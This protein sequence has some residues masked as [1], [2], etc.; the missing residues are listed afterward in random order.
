MIFRDPKFEEVRH[1][2]MHLRPRSAEE[3]H[4]MA[5]GDLGHLALVFTD[6]P[7][8][9]WVAYHEDKPAAIFGAYRLHGGVWQ[10]FG[11]GTEDYADVLRAVTK[12]FR[13]DV[14]AAVKAA[15]A[16]RAQALSPA[17]HHETHK[18]LKMLGGFEEATLF[19]YG[20]GGEDVKV[21]AWHEESTD[22][23]W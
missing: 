8:L 22:V 4:M 21:F 7:G 6:A 20:R 1:V 10:L 19:G 11:F 2:F 23:R 14:F 5:D 12:C 16:H 9:K 18:W 13:R 17:G 3:L 15:G